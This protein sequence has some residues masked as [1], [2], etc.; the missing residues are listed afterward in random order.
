MRACTKFGGGEC[1]D[2]NLA[3]LPKAHTLVEARQNESRCGV[4]VVFGGEKGETGRRRQ[5]KS[6]F[7]N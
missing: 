2:F 1:K 6:G 4:I 5:G 3:R 7:A